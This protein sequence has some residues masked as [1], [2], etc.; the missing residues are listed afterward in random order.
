MK[1]DEWYTPPEE[2]D[3]IMGYVHELFPE[4]RDAKILRP[5]Y[6]GG[7]YQAEDYTDAIVIDN[8]PFSILSKIITWY[9]ER[10]IKYVLFAPALTG[11]TSRTSYIFFPN[12]VIQY[13]RGA[14]PTCLVT[15]LTEHDIIYGEGDGKNYDLRYPEF[16]A[17]NAN[18]YAKHS[19]QRRIFRTTKFLD[20]GK[21]KR[22]GLVFRIEEELT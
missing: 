7:D 15:N 22:Y 14:L 11:S 9:Q 20:R 21:N 16:T 4:T 17:A 3:R 5:F 12:N 19:R 18:V 13:S 6:P 2:Y 1:N 10:D 8:P